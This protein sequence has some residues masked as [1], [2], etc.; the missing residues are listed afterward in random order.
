MPDDTVHPNETHRDDTAPHRA[1]LI[2]GGTPFDWTRAFG[3]AAPRILD[4]GCGDGRFL[5][6]S[7]LANPGTDHL[8]IEVLAPLAERGL[9][10]V[11]R[12]ELGNLRLCIGDA[13]KWLAQSA[14]DASIDELHVY[15]PQPYYDPSI[16]ALGM[17]SAA[18][19]ERA[20]HVVR[21]GGR[22]V[23]QTDSKPHGK[24]LLL[25]VNKHFDPTIQRGPWPDAPRGRTRREEVA[26]R[27]KLA[28]L[29]VVATRRDVPLDVATPPPYFEA[30]RPGLQT[31]RRR[32]GG[33]GVRHVLF[34]YPQSR[35]R[36]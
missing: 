33:P 12:L 8:G 5:I 17:L 10:E 3:R 18:F 2:A 6:A 7:A 34:V 9:R 19:I 30:G 14:D 1:A 25:A 32:G 23:L 24:H 4:V 16:V 28:I 21:P 36:S 26:Q 29:R 27:K 35:P 22:L 11:E 31:V 15:H 20:W 13:V